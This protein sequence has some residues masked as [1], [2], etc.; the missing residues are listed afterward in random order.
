MI[1]DCPK[2]R[3]KKVIMGLGENI[4]GNTWSDTIAFTANQKMANFYTFTYSNF[5]QQLLPPRWRKLKHQSW[6]TALFS[7]LQ[8]LHDLFFNNYIDYDL[9]AV[10]TYFVSG[11]LIANKGDLIRFID[12]SVWECQTNNTH[13]NL[14]N[15]INGS[16]YNPVNWY[17]ILNDSIGIWERKNYNCQKMTFEYLLNRYFNPTNDPNKIYITNNNTRLLLTAMSGVL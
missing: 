1:K 8:W 16:L 10:Y 7:P 13:V 3:K 12:N 14:D 9:N 6:L 5:V 15:P 17:K 2:C 4:A 11:S